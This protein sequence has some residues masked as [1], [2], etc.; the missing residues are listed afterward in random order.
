MDCF[1]SVI[2]PVWNDARRVERCIAALENQSIDRSHYEIIIADN[3]SEDGT[4][5][6]LS[7][8]RNIIL[9][10]ECAPGSYAARNKALQVAKGEFIAFTDSDCIPNHEW[11]ESHLKMFNQGAE[12]GLSAGFIDFFIEDGGGVEDVAFLFESMFSMNQES[13]VSQGLAITANWM[14]PKA[15][16]CDIG[17][18]DCSLK[19]GGDHKMASEITNRRYKVVYCAEALVKHPARNVAELFRKRR[20][21][22]G[23]SWDK[24]TNRL[25]FFLILK[26]I[27]TL[28]V[29]RIITV[30]SFGKLR[31]YDRLSLG[32][33][34]SRMFL[35]SLVE[36]MQLQLGKPS[37]RS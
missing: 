7:S 35:V 6:F 11:L 4:F 36:L 12:I 5:E 22:I 16:L 26:G 3:G 18:F 30:F 24:T 2:V 33:F 17:G 1:V 34:L 10:Q 23:G 28:Y 14:S 19:S 8:L 32:I 21:V 20:R 37:E 9:V 29:K 25:R 15:V 27:I 13:Y 31:F